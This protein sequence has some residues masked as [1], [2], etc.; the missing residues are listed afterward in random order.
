MQ[1]PLIIIW[2]HLHE[3]WV[4]YFYEGPRMFGLLA[5][6]ILPSLRS[7]LISASIKLVGCNY[8]LKEVLIHIID[9]IFLVL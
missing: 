4:S 5:P 6:P 7:A 3:K 1:F 9:F 8:V 2:T